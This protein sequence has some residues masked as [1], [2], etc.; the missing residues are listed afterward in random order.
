M[1]KHL[2][3]IAASLA[4]AESKERR[5]SA[6]ATPSGWALRHRRAFATHPV[7]GIIRAAA[8]YADDYQ[9]RW[10]NG[11]GADYVLG[12]YWEK[13][14]RSARGM[15]NGDLGNMDGGTLD[16]LI[17]DMLEAEGFNPDIEGERL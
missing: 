13:I 11:I 17:A 15:L 9:T 4:N 8:V 1:G 10:E 6:Y 2:D 12:D 14:L 7:A 16:T 5:I 3:L